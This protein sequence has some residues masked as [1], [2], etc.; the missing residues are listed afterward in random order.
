[1][2]A[3]FAVLSYSEVLFENS[4]ILGHY[5]SN[6]AQLYAVQLSPHEAVEKNRELDWRI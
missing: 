4:E 3:F 1:M 2:A 6:T 5:S